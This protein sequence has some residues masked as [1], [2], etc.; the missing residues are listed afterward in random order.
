[1]VNRPAGG[2]RSAKHLRAPLDWYIEPAERSSS[3]STLS[4]SRRGWPDHIWDG[5]CGRGHRARSREPVRPPRSLAPTC[6]RR[7]RYG[8][9]DFRDFAWCKQDILETSA[10][11]GTSAPSAP[12]VLCVEPAVRL[13]EGIAERII[14]HVVA[15]RPRRAAFLVPIAFLASNGRYKLFTRDLRPSHT[16]S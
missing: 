10:R 5:C 8:D 3:C 11:R 4:T 13:F 2:A 6:D 16:R 1:V 15:P 12:V 7:G 9:F 14:R